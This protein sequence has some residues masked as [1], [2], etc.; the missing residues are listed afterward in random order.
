[1]DFLGR[2]STLQYPTP[3]SIP[4]VQEPDPLAE[5]QYETSL[6]EFPLFFIS[7]RPN[8][9]TNHLLYSDTISVKGQTIPR[10][11]KV[12]WSEKYGPG[13]PS[14][15]ATFF[16]LFQFWAETGFT[17][18]W[19]HFSSIHNLLN[20]RG[21]TKGKDNYTRI[22]RDLHCL[23]NIYIEAK[24]AFYDKSRNKYVDASFHLFEGLWLEKETQGNPDANSR[25]FIRVS[26][27]LFSSVQNN[28][29]Y[30]GAQEQDFYRLTGLQQ[31]LFLYLRK[32][33]I[34]QKFHVRNMD[35]FARQLPL[36]ISAK[37]KLKQELK[38]AIEDLMASGILPSLGGY[39]FFTSEVTGKDL[40]RFDR[41]DSPQ[42]NLFKDELQ[43]VQ[44]PDEEIEYRFSLITDVLCD[45]HSYPF[46]RKI[47]A[48]CDTDTICQALSETKVTAQEHTRQGRACKVGAVFVT[49][50]KEIMVRKGK[51]LP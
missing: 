15:A 20:R 51:V 5:T 9:K 21:L 29:F 44:T 2:T 3:L 47:A 26:E 33:F 34:F 43:V 49:R 6:A 38:N 40:I 13:T 31:R 18:H 32:M 25:G 17:S 19:I 14:T 37:F 50:I 45:E 23:C 36:F 10:Q 16:A 7:S 1:M 4:E 48:Y 39:K 27:T 42:L 41:S 8:P 11:W 24:N 12:T 30:L 22:I 28:I 35:D 46:Y